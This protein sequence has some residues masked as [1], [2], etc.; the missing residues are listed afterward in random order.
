MREKEARERESQGVARGG[1]TKLKRERGSASG[2]PGCQ[3][4][5]GVG[6]KGPKVKVSQG[7]ARRRES[8]WRRGAESASGYPK[9]QQSARV[10]ETETGGGESQGA[11]QRMKCCKA[12]RA[13]GKEDGKGWSDCK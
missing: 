8:K 13:V 2:C 7:V 3:Q 12:K 1:E 9:S 4:L 10:K 5:G 11:L 6:E